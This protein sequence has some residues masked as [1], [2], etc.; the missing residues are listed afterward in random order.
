M[1]EPIYRRLGQLE[2]EKLRD[3]RP[4]DR[5]FAEQG[6]AAGARRSWLTTGELGFHSALNEMPAGFEVPPHSHD[7]SEL[8]VVLAGNCTVVDGTQLSAGDVAAIPAGM[9]YGFR[10]GDD[11][12]R[13]VVIRSEDAHTTLA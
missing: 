13:F 5:A 6:I 12:L 4:E 11:G 1:S 2:W 9:K 8:F 3:I 10:V 7:S